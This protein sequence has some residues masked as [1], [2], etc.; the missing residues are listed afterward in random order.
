MADGS[1]LKQQL[2][3]GCTNLLIR[4]TGGQLGDCIRIDSLPR[5]QE[6]QDLAWRPLTASL[7]AFAF[8]LDFVENN[9]K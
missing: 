6:D 8:P 4:K 2:P 1:G 5:V 7:R 9:E 3:T